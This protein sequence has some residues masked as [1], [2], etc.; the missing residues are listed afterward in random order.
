[1]TI[2]IVLSLLWLGAVTPCGQFKEGPAPTEAQITALTSA[3]VD[4]IYVYDLA[5]EYGDIGVNESNDIQKVTIFIMPK[6]SNNAIRVIY[7]LMPLGEIIRMFF[8]SGRLAIPHLEPDS[9]FPATQPSFRTVYM[10]N[11]ELCRLKQTW[12]RRT[13]SIKLAPTKADIDA[14]RKR[15]LERTGFV[16]N[17]RIG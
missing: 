2:Q 10:D 4:E 16:P 15:H 11:D 5:K 14:A 6:T 3:I 1:M 7:P 9:N 17:R 13:V 8:L 12:I